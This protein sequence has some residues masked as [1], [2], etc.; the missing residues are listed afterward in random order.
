MNF[1]HSS[2][3]KAN[4]LVLLTVNLALDMEKMLPSVGPVVAFFGNCS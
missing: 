1:V 2:Q 4:D 3:Q